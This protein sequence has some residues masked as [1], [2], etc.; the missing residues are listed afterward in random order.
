M[1]KVFFALAAV[2]VLGFASSCKKD[3]VSCSGVKVCE[4]DYTAANGVSWSDYK[5][6]ALAS[7]CTESN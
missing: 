3:C 4:S 5:S 7:G 2:A 6:A 1:K